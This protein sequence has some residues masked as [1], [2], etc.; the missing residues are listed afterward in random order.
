MLTLHV[1]A[2]ALA[3]DPSR[4]GLVHLEHDPPPPGTVVEVLD[5]DGVRA[6]L[7]VHADGTFTWP[8]DHDPWVRARG[9]GLISAPG[10]MPHPREVVL[11]LQPEQTVEVAVEPAAADIL[12]IA[13][14]IG[15]ACACS[16]PTA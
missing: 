10:R 8:E 9:P 6:T 12:V 7:P 16:A 2:L 15:E 3:Q 13:R 4:A 14:S 5:V 11:A 1:V